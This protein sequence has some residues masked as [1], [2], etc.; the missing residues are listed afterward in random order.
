MSDA[1]RVKYSGWPPPKKE[2]AEEQPAPK[3]KQK[4]APEQP[5]E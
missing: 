3:K 1:E 4:P 5:T 2:T